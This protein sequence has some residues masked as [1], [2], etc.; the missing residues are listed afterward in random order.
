VVEPKEGLRTILLTPY[1]LGD[2]ELSNRMVMSAMTRSRAV[3]DGVPHPAA[4]TYYSQRASAGL[5][6]T[7]GS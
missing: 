5:I 4:A 7:E 3:K 6:V 1:R 2:L